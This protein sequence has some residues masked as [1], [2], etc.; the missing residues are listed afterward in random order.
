MTIINEQWELTADSLKGRGRLSYYEIGASRL[1][2][3]ANA[4]YG[5][6]LYDWPVHMAQK[7]N[8]DTTSS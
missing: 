7:I 8:F 2:E 5:G 3:T 6:E 1:T 4:P